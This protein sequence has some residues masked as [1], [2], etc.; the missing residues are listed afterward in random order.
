MRSLLLAKELL[1][2]IVV[3]AACVHMVGWALWIGRETCRRRRLHLF[4]LGLT[5][6]EILEGV[7][8]VATVVGA[9]RQLFF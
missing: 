7:A 9:A 2:Y 8:L 6:L 5:G 1:I 4:S 3:L